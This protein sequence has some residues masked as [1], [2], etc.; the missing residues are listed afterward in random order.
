MGKGGNML[1]R[2][3]TKI[4]TMKLA[5]VFSLLCLGHVTVVDVVELAMPIQIDNRY[6]QGR[7]LGNLL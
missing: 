7:F 3:G 6:L 1:Q 5:E 2:R 4:L